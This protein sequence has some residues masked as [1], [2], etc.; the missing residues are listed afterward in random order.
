MHKV[1]LHMIE[2]ATD[3][4]DTSIYR[5]Y[6]TLVLYSIIIGRTSLHDY[7]IIIIIVIILPQ[8]MHCEEELGIV[9][10]DV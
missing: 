2:E 6:S 1:L 7:N 5:M 9:L 8:S 10:L 3:D 4:M